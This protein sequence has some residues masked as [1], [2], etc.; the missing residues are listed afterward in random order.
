MEKW[1]TGLA[2]VGLDGLVWVH[3]TRI[4]LGRLEMCTILVAATSCGITDVCMYTDMR[5]DVTPV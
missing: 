4:P 5:V 2:V 1:L 3:L